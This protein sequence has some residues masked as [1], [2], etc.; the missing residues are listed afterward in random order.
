MDAMTALA[1]MRNPEE[2]RNQSISTAITLPSWKLYE[3]PVYNSQQQ[4]QLTRRGRGHRLHLPL[5]ARKIAASLWDLSFFRPMMDS[6]LEIVRSQIAELRL[7]LQLE[8]EARKKLESMNKRLAKELSEERKGREAVE[9]V[10]DVLAKEIAS[11]KADIDRMRRE[12]EEERKMLRMAEVLREERIQMKLTEA[13]ILFEEKLLEL[14]LDFTKPKGFQFQFHSPSPMDET[15]AGEDGKNT[16]NEVATSMTLSKYGG[17]YSCN[18]KNSNSTT[19]SCFDN[20]GGGGRS[21]INQN[22]NQRRTSAD[23]E[24]PHIKR[25]IKGFVEFPRVVREIGPRGRHSS[26]KL[27]CQKAQLRLLLRHRSPIRSHNLIT[28]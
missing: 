10:C 25:G 28:S 22:Q 11:D 23:A 8:R 12:M 21:I 13:K 4:Q 5:S 27:E 2:L 1:L 24:N 9:R 26:S 19:F 17:N 7:E 14:E 16:C 3:N 20:G 15:K 6:E 18:S